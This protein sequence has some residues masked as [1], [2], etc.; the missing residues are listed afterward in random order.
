MFSKIYSYILGYCWIGSTKEL[1]SDILQF[2]PI[3]EGE[4]Q[5]TSVA[6]LCTIYIEG[7]RL[8]YVTETL[9]KK[10]IVCLGF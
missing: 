3:F 8:F 9:V 10:Y 1:V 7:H 6:G 5:G 2:V 4:N